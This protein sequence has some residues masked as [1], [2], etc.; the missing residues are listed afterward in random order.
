APLMR[1]SVAST[2]RKSPDHRD[3]KASDQ[4]YTHN[5]RGALGSKPII[6]RS[7]LRTGRL[8]R[9]EAKRM[10]EGRRWLG[11][12]SLLLPRPAKTLRRGDHN[13]HRLWHTRSLAQT[14]PCGL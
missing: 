12:A 13:S 14:R 10:N 9:C 11:A 2:G 8:I 3:Q 1:V 6:N 4:E 5:D 7:P